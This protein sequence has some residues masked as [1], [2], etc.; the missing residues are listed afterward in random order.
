[1]NEVVGAEHR[2]Q[3]DTI[4][5]FCREILAPRAAE[6][7]R[8]GQSTTCHLPELGK[9]GVMGLNLPEAYGGVGLPATVLFDAIALMSGACASTASMVTAHWLATDSIL[10]GGDEVIRERILP[11]AAAGVTPWRICTERA[12]CRLESGRHDDRRDT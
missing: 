8:S 10:L 7:D 3:L 4:E 2:L 1:M 6:I 9:L 5:R 11:D 12:Q